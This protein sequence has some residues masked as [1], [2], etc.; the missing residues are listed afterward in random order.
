MLRRLRNQDSR[1]FRE[2][3]RA[4]RVGWWFEHVRFDLNVKSAYAVGRLVQPWRYKS[5]T[6]HTNRWAKYA[7]AGASPGPSTVRD[8]EVLSSRSA[9]IFRS[10]LWR[11]LDTSDA[12]G[13]SSAPQGSLSNTRCTKARLRRLAHDDHVDA[14]AALV[15]LLRKHSSDP[16]SHW[17]L[18]IGVAIY[19]WLLAS[20][21]TPPVQEIRHEL[22]AYLNDTIFSLARTRDIALAFCSEEFEDSRDL[23]IGLYTNHLPAQIALAK[24][25]LAIKLMYGEHGYFPRLLFAPHFAACSDNS[26]AKTVIKSFPD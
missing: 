4:L 11:A 8:A 24:R 10:C 26:K 17:P 18:R 6:E 22:C 15:C 25:T 20:S 19:R 12:M 16:N 14:L 7:R 9:Q 5:A 2:A 3:I 23:L 21:I 13:F 1:G